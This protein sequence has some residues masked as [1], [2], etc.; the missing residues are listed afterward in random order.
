[1]A[2]EASERRGVRRNH[3]EHPARKWIGRQRLRPLPALQCLLHVLDTTPI[4]PTPVRTQTQCIGRGTQ[5]KHTGRRRQTARTRTHSMSAC[6]R[7]HGIRQL[8][9]VFSIA[10][11][12][13][14]YGRRP[15]RGKHLSSSS[16]EDSG[17]LPGA[18]GRTG[19]SANAIQT[20][21]EGRG[22][23]GEERGWRWGQAERHRL[24]TATPGQCARKQAAR[25]ATWTA[26]AGHKSPRCLCFSRLTLW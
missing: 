10:A 21:A 22:A 18:V 11:T 5:A 9:A 19:K 2:A 4:P 24:L 14:E 7:T 23:R 13:A 15:E 1:M 16:G 25:R 26:A 12:H 8:P 3:W 20:R 17:H 6:V